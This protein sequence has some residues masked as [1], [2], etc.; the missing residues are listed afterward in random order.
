MTEPDRVS[1]AK[2]GRAAL[3]SAAA[4]IFLERG[5]EATG[6]DAIIARTGGSKRNIYGEFGNKEGLFTA[7]VTEKVDGALGALAIDVGEDRDLREVLT[8][9]GC[10]L[11][12]S[13]VSPALIG[14]YRIAV[15]EHARF[16]ALVR[17]F[18]E[19]G[20]GRASARLAELLAEATDRGEID[21][22]DCGRAADQ[23][24][25]MI[26]GNL[27]LQ[28]VLGLRPAPDASELRRLVSSAVDIFLD[29]VRPTAAIRT[30]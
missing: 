23:F 1:R 25:G 7:I 24:F 19:Q 20:P 29:G 11:L 3:L 22:P 15:T 30:A 12:D 4:E 28:I 21:T 2:V 5:Y 26:R 27:H 14:I 9:F 8:A 6:I 16:P 18:Y 10:Q 13:L 17:R